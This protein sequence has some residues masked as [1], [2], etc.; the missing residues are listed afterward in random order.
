MKSYD[1]YKRLDWNRLKF[2]GRKKEFKG[3]DRV[4]FEAAK[5]KSIYRMAHKYVPELDGRTES[6][7]AVDFCKLGRG[8][9]Y[10]K[11]LLPGGKYIW[12][13]SPLFG[14]NDYNKSVF[15]ENTARNRRKAELINALASK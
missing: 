4:A 3:V 15:A 5:E 1:I 9:K 12:F 7:K 13:A 11:T 10:E 14:M 8:T 6:L 2:D